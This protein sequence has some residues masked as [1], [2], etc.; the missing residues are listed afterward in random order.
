M[1]NFL[2]LAE[3]AR[4]ASRCC[5]SA[6]PSTTI[7]E[8]LMSAEYILN[9]GNRNVILC[10]RGIRTFE[11]ATRNTLD[12][13]AVPGDQARQPPADGGGPQPRHGPARPRAADVAAGVAAGADGVI[14]EV[15]PNPEHALCDGPSRCPRTRSPSTPTACST[16]RAG[17]ASR[18]KPVVESGSVT[19]V[20]LIGVGLM[21]GSLGLAARERAGGRRCARLQP[22]AGHPRPRPGARRHH[23]RL[24]EGSMATC[25]GADLIFVCTP[26]RMVVGHVRE[27][28]A[29][30]PPLRRCHQR[31]K[32]QGPA[33][34]RAVAG[35]AAP[36]H[37]RA[38]AVRG[39]DRRR[40]QRAELAVP[41][42]DLLRHP[43]R[44]RR[45][46]R[47]PAAVRVPRRHRRPPSGRRPGRAR[48]ARWPS[49]VTCRTCWPTC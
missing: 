5:S 12:L 23:D 15:H 36:L 27:A 9:E 18:L 34:A 4:P 24:R 16:S 41:G 19:T 21:G 26:V 7:D 8:L 38:P 10:E 13:S 33:H 30:A 1:Q 11:A 3:S 45:R 49:S 28:L 2:L 29:A 43:R 39:G 14:V 31:R 44:P 22:D 17:P 25:A 6:G 37:R 40:S 47:L 48:P 32:H 42:R 46:G 20:A 35:G